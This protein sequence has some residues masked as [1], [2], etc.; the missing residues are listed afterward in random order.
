[1]KHV[2]RCFIAALALIF[3]P[4]AVRADDFSDLKSDITS[5]LEK[6][7]ALYVLNDESLNY[8]WEA[9][10]GLFDPS[11]PEG[12]ES[13]TQIGLNEQ[14]K[15]ANMIASLRSDLRTLLERVEKIK[16]NSETTDSQRSSI[17]DLLEETH[18]VERNL[19]KLDNG[20]VLSGS[21]HPFVKF[22]IEYGKK[23]HIELCETYKGDVNVCDKS[24]PTLGRDRPDLVRINS[25][26]LTVFE[27]SR[28]Q[29]SLAP[30]RTTKLKW[31]L[32]PEAAI[33]QDT[34]NQYQNSILP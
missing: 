22:A 23:K 19:E 30:S 26:G 16:A 9:Y 2:Y 1:M 7:K 20:V 27:L 18:K 8:I 33:D 17:D 14:N 21:N 6:A 24:F 13:A 25:D 29:N 15:E 34:R 5:W 3:L 4:P 11:L 28:G 31:Q 12:Y 32:L 10:C